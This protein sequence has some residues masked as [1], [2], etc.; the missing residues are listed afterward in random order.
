MT[1]ATPE[2]CNEDHHL[3]ADKGVIYNPLPKLVKRVEVYQEKAYNT[4]KP[5]PNFKCP[6]CFKDKGH[7]DLIKDDG[8]EFDIM[9]CDD[10]KC[11]WWGGV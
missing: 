10:S 6:K 4:P 3:L 1:N 2:T 9:V 5:V 8:H 7:F 11:G